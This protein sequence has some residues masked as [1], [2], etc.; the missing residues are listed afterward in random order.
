LPKTAQQGNA[1]RQL[2]RTTARA[3]GFRTLAEWEMETV[4]RMD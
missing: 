3:S 1:A 4:W 2:I